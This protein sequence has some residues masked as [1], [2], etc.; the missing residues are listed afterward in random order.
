MIYVVGDIHGHL[1][2]LER[3]LALIEADGGP[4][5]QIVFLGDFVDRGPDS[6]G[7]IQRLIEAQAAGKPWRAVLGNHDR[8]FARFVRDGRVADPNV[9]SGKTWL[10]PNL[11]GMA[12]LASYM[13][14]VAAPDAPRGDPGRA[15]D[16][17]G[18]VAA[19]CHAVPDAHLDFVETL[20]VYLESADHIYVHAGIRPGVP[21]PQQDEDDLVWIRE[22]FLEDTRDH[23]RLVVHGHT[24]LDHPAHYGNRVNLDGGTGYGRPLHPALIDGREVWLLTDDGRRPLTPV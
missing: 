19:A 15:R 8:M 10:H 2:Q 6:R 16:V 23:G 1:D 11:G 13:G 14:E 20:P 17:A 9:L 24:A 22:G 12:T 7:V 3:A 5:A 4:G 18:L 21:M